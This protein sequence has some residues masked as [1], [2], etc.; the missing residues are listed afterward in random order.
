M[1]LQGFNLSLLF[2]TCIRGVEVPRTAHQLYTVLVDTTSDIGDN[3]LF[4]QID[5]FSRGQPIQEEYFGRQLS[6][7]QDLLKRLLPQMYSEALDET[8][9]WLLTNITLQAVDT[10]QRSYPG[11]KPDLRKSVCLVLDRHGYVDFDLLQHLSETSRLSKICDNG[12]NSM[13]ELF[14]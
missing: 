9:K 5:M 2:E 11:A 8:M 3:F 12:N 14:H 4:S 13:I 7:Y 6:R 10:I 1:F